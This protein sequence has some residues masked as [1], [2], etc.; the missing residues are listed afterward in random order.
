MSGHQLYHIAG[1]Q[2]WDSR[3]GNMASGSYSFT[4]LLSSSGGEWTPLTIYGDKHRSSCQFHLQNNPRE[5]VPSY[6]FGQFPTEFEHI[7]WEVRPC[8]Q[9]D[10]GTSEV[11]G[12][13]GSLQVPSSQTQRATSTRMWLAWTPLF[14]LAQCRPG[15]LYFKVVGQKVGGVSTPI[16][17]WLLSNK[18]IWHL[19][20]IKLL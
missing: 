1:K 2:W 8:P 11:R 16:K 12:V 4:P 3:G 18:E 7:Y 14:G 9:R 6:L 20:F 17:A 13:H 5:S 15:A 19:C 10:G